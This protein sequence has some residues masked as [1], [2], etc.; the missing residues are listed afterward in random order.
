MMSVDEQIIPFKGKS[1]LK[2]YNPKKPKKWGYKVFVCSGST[3]LIH[4]FEFYVGQIQPCPGKTDLGASGNIVFRLMQDVPR[5]CWHQVFFDNWFTSILLQ[6]LLWKEGIA[7]VG[8]V[9]PNRLKGCTFPPDKELS[10]KGRG[11]VVL[12]TGVFDGVQLNAVRW[13]DNKALTLLSTF[14]AVEL[15]KK[16][17]KWDKKEKKDIEVECPSII[18]LYNAFMGGVDLLD[19][20]V[21]L[22]TSD[23][24]S[25]T[26]ES[27]F[28]SSIWL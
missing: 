11:S 13:M 6:V 24:K 1:S 20:L 7:S 26:T 10:K 27:L 14:A 23:P 28:I 22:Y 18:I 9:R 3:G 19:S 15:V 12:K 2:Q 5:H 8:T 4:N 25:S 17:R 16:V 21:A